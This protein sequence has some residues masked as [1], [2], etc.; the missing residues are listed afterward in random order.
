[1]VVVVFNA[2]QTSSC[3]A[4]LQIMSLTSAVSL[5]RNYYCGDSMNCPSICD[6]M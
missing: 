2:L 6:E 4:H 1:V 5:F 3:C